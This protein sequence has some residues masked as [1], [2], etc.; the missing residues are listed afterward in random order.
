M[1]TLQSVIIESSNT[2]LSGF[3]AGIARSVATS[4]SAANQLGQKLAAL[5][6]V[7]KVESKSKPG[8]WY[9]L[10]NVSTIDGDNQTQKSANNNRVRGPRR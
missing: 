5:V 9:G 3:D 8:S 4:R 2:S 10:F 1:D 7:S 6:P